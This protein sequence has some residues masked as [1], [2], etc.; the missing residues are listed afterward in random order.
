MNMSDKRVE[1]SRFRH[2]TTLAI[3]FALGLLVGWFA[4]SYWLER[5]TGLNL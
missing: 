2:W 5:W 4:A 1:G 3:C